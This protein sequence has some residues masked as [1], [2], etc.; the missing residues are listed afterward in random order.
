MAQA[1]LGLLQA[2]EAASQGAHAR[3]AGNNV[4]SLS[5]RSRAD[6]DDELVLHATQCFPCLRHAF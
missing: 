3:P 2:L 1:H 4:L 6:V 5:I